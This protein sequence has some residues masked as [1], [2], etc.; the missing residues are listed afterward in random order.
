MNW[1]LLILALLC[2]WRII[3]GIRHGFVDEMLRLL[4]L[5]TALFVIAVAILLYSSW[6][7]GNTKN[8]ILSVLVIIIVGILY[9]ILRF[10]F[11]SL[12]TVARLPLIHLANSALGAA[13]G[14][15][16]VGIAVWILY[17]ALAIL[18]YGEISAYIM[19]ATRQNPWLSQWYEMNALVRWIAEL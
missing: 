17:L 18:P 5:L 10:V 8:V 12:D 4:S 2:V 1:L 13:V 15:L 6:K 7:T 14:I 3:S 16:E 11:R 19:E 9:R